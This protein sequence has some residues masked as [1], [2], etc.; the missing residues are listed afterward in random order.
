[1]SSSNGKLFIVATPFGNLDDLT[2]RA[3]DVLSSVDFILAEDTRHSGKLLK[4]IGTSKPLIAY[5]DHNEREISTEI[6]QQVLSGKD[7]ALIS[8]AGT[9]L[10]NDPGYQLV[11]AAHKAGITVVPIPGACAVIAALSVSGLP[12]ERFQFEGFIP[13]KRTE[14]LAR[15]QALSD[16]THTLI[17]YEAP[18]RILTALQDAIDCFGADRMACIV[19][20]M[21]KIYEDV[22][23]ANLAELHSWL[24]CHS[25][26]QKGEF[27][28]L[29]QGAA[30]QK[31]SFEEAEA[32]RILYILKRE[33]S[34]KK[35]SD[36][37]AK[38]TGMKK[39]YMYQLALKLDKTD[40]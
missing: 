11:S 36:L 7:C 23:R 13:A 10:I 1:M 34:T 37:T 3:R 19:R 26:K 39:N 5:H 8:D 22:K 35:A 17:F 21:T 2:D 40:E 30:A 31:T 32:Q 24:Q 15:Y 29:I 9:P 12:T 25:N 33:F 20:E 4:Y 18:H 38:I 6:L 28:L 14:R 16:K 27:V